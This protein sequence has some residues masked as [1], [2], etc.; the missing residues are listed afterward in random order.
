MSKGKYVLV[1]FILVLSLLSCGGPTLPEAVYLEYK[2]L[3]KEI[4]FNKDVKPILSDK[5]FACH[6]PD[7]AKVKGGLQLHS[8]QLAFRPSTEYPGKVAIKPGD[9]DESEVFHRIM[10]ND[11]NYVMP[12]PSSHLGLSN[13][14]KAVLTKWIETGAVYE[15]HWAFIK[16]RKPSIPKVKGIAQ[17][18]IDNFV[19]KRLEEIDLLPSG[20]ADKEHLLRR[21]SFD[22]TGLPPSLEEIDSFLNDSSPN[23]YERQVDRLLAS[24]HYGEQMAL[25]WMDLSRFADTHGYT[26]DRYRDMSPW[27]DWV[28]ESFNKN[29]P[30]DQFLIW[31]LAGDLMENPSREMILATGFNRL[32]PQNMEGGIVNE[33]FLVEYAVDRAS[34]MGQAFMGL[35][36]AC[37][38]CHDHKYDPISHKNF[39]EL[40]G[41]F[42]NI[43]ESGQ[44]AYND[45]MPVPNLLLPTK[46][47]EQVLQFMRSVLD[48]SSQEIEKIEKGEITKDFETWLNANGPRTIQ[49]TKTTDGL[50]AYFALNDPSLKNSIRPNQRASMN[51]DYLKG[52]N[53]TL[54]AGKMGNGVVFD[55]DSWLDLNEVGVFGRSDEFSI[56]LWAN[57][58]E[59]IQDG[60][61][62]HKGSGA[63][64]YNWRGYHLK[65]VDNKLELMMA[66]TAPDNAIIKVSKSGFPRDQWINLAITYD[67]SSSAKGLKLFI[68]GQLQETLV[69]KDNL[70]K[71]ILFGIDPEPGLQLGA[72]LRGKGIQGAVIDEIKVF[73]RQLSTIEVMKLAE[74]PKIAPLTTT[75]HNALT[76]VDQEILREH[77]V[78]VISK[79]AQNLKTEQKALRKRYVDSSE[80]IQEVMVMKESDKPV[81]TYI[82]ERG[83]Y[84]AKGQE[85]F[86]NTPEAFFLMP[87][88]YPKNRM[89]LAKWLVHQDHPLT[90]RVAV[91]R[92]WQQYF[93]TGMVKTSEDFGNQGEMPSHPELLDW[94]AIQ[95]MQSGWNVKE[96]QKLIVMSNTYRQSSLNSTEKF[97]VDP[98]NRLLSRGP[99]KRLSG[100]MLRDNALAT[101]GLLNRAIG[102]KSVKPYQPEG[103]W[104]ING[105]HYEQDTGD[106]LYRRSM[107]T[108]WKRS[109][110][111]PTVATFDAPARDACT[112]RRQ[113]TN[114]PLQ[115]LILLNDPTY[116][117]A[118]RVLGKKMA[119]FA[120]T[121]KAIATVYKQITGV[122]LKPQELE[123]LMALHK[124]EY[125][126]F[127]NNI[128]KT[129]G[130]LN[131]GQFKLGFEDDKALV[132]AYAV[133]ANTVLNADATI[134]KR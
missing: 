125:Q 87:K 34:T 112:I 89:G 3:P 69:I 68:D 26:V 58:P 82:L 86:P 1:S 30:Y 133:V 96:L 59:A 63:I 53:V 16:P 41:F 31:Q 106:N 8:A 130:W 67:G 60:N 2:S 124:E 80:T 94:M 72:R 28:I 14:E 120:D 18:P 5:C 98:E 27:R 55:G 38:R 83:L 52:L 64:L 76:S 117:E 37:A 21:L 107:Y 104:R 36:V 19:L 115:A 131:T 77:Y 110:P 75:N 119:S 111:N 108:I 39:Y 70:Y 15:G 44:I 56:S 47:Q 22:I 73:N 128:N 7:V 88:E 85:V 123:L 126:K 40:T 97:N 54:A 79:K 102:G 17:N 100:E 42:N 10:S 12:E 9:L 20:M 129:K 50:T 33:E 90:A 32:H 71:D 113:E 74:N 45:A 43:D 91:N 61:I 57:I 103:L 121:Q 11:P 78:K 93:G 101:S 118:S 122:T 24:P 66:H 29:M 46:E 48:R 23:A 95:F 109:V 114:T 127:K 134:I 132:A 4:D 92:Y 35:T 116:V 51:R 13:Y 62:F 6:G 84:S 99:S 65:I 49:G 25:H 105:A 81:K